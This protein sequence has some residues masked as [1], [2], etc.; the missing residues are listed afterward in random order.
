MIN[1]KEKLIL[2]TGATSGIGRACAEIYAQNGANIII[3]GR[4]ND[5]LEKIQKELEDKY[6]VKVIPYCFD[7]RNRK[8]VAEFGQELKNNNLTPYIFINN[9]GLAKGISALQDGNIDDWEEMID[10]N[11]K[12]F[13]YTARA[14]LPLMIKKNTGTVI[15]LGSVAGSQ[16]Y[17]GGN[18]YNATK[19]AVRALNQAMNMDLLK[20]NIRISTIEPGAVETEFSLVRF[21][22]DKEKAD[23]VYKGFL[24]LTASDIA[25]II[26]F[27]TTLPEHVNIQNLLVTPTA[28]RSATLFN[29]NFKSLIILILLIY[30]IILKVC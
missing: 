10:T 14:V 23:N 4:R 19:H 3:T 24:P 30:I 15:N 28:Q 26:Y 22:G 5:R 12:G 7:V 27:M 17:P 18:V 8:L 1:V 2:I 16:V 11:I 9:A 13:L 20:T 29:R 21:N 6:N 25:D